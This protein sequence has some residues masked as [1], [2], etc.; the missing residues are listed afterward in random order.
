MMA[1]FSA[2]TRM[3]HLKA[4]IHIF[5]FLQ[6][7]PRCCLVFDDSYVQVDDGP[8]KDW[9]EFYPNVIEDVPPNETELRGKAVQMIAFV[10]SDHAGDLLT[11][12]SRTRV[13]VYLNRA[14][15]VWHS[16]K[17]NSVESSTF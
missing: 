9:R 6:H 15:I 14:L 10:D 1:A 7:H 5:S 17:Q 13:L 4:I 12:H 3:G 8:N 16:K 2:A 11:R